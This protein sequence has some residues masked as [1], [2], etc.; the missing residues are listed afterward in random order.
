MEHPAWFSFP[1]K[2]TSLDF[3]DMYFVSLDDFTDFG[4]ISVIFIVGASG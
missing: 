2:M 1:E 3:L 4:P